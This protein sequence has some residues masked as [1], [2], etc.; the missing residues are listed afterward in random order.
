MGLDITDDHIKTVA[1]N[2]RD[3]NPSIKS[4]IKTEGG[5]GMNGVF[6]A[7]WVNGIIG[8]IKRKR[9]LVR[10]NLVSCLLRLY[11]YCTIKNER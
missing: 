11:L 8:Y 6:D 4:L 2:P 1:F 3:N 7:F 5:T 9:K 10:Q